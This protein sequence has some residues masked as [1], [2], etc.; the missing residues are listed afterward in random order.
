[1]INLYVANTDNAWF[2]FLSSEDNLTEVNF[3]VAWHEELS[4]P[5]AGRTSRVS[6]Q[7]PSPLF[8]LI[9]HHVFAAERLHGD[10]TKVLSNR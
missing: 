5:R 4:S 9:K 1:M 8:E 10:D 7:E 2:D 6:I 3:L